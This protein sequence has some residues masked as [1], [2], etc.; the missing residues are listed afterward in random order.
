MPPEIGRQTG[1]RPRFKLS[2]GSR[3]A[4]HAP[5]GT[6]K[7]P[8]HPP[9]KPPCNA[10]MQR[11]MQ[12]PH[13]TPPMQAPHLVVDLNQ[14]V[15]VPQLHAAAHH[16]PQLLTHLRV[17]WGVGGAGGWGGRVGRLIGGR[18]RGGWLGR[19]RGVGGG[20]GRGG[21]LGRARRVGGGAGRSDVPGFRR[22]SRRESI[23]TSAPVKRSGTG[24]T[25][26]HRSKPPPRCTALKSRSA[27]F[28]PE[29]TDDA[30]PPPI[31]M[32]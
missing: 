21:W 6:R 7:H 22:Q 30:A 1:A 32:R 20:V 31:P 29:G 19:A 24:Q 11:P 13:A 2:W 23:H 28:E 16:A 17:A 25:F 27:E 12:T 5:A 26:W 8:A 4:S 3:P 15:L 9:L 14:G 10:P 18:G